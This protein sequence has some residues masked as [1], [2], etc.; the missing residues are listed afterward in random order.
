MI[1]INKENREFHLQGPNT[2][3]IFNVM[4]NEQLGHLYFGKKIRHRESFKHFFYQPE[5]GIG[6]IAH[7]EDDP[8]FSLEYYKQEYPSYGTTDFRKPAFELES[9]DGSRVSDFVYKGY[10][11]YKGKERLDGLPSTYVE[12]EDEAN[13]LEIELKDEVL[14]CKLFLTYTVYKN[15]DVITRNA[16]FVNHGTEKIDINR[17][18]SFALDLPDY[19]YEI[20]HLS[21]AWARERFIKT[22]KLEVGSQ[23]I[24]STRGASSAHQNP[25]IILKRPNTTEDSGESIGFAL[26]YSG[27][28]LAH[29][30]VD[31]FDATRVTMGI[32]PFDFKWNL[33]PGESFTTPE[34]IIVYS[35]NGMNE[36]SKTFHKLFRERVARGEW[37]DKE[38]PILV[39]NWE[40][41]YFDFNED[42]IVAMASKAKK[43]GF[44]LF[45]LD[46]GWFGKR[47]DDKTS[48][49]DWFPNL[50]KLPNGVKGLGERVVNEDI[51]FGLWFEP[52]MISKNSKLYEEH[53]DWILGVKNRRLSMG[54]NQ[55]ILDLSKPEV[56]KYIVD[57]LSERFSEAPISYVKWDMNR[58]MTEIT[59]RDLPHKY[60]L[61]LYE[62]LEELTT[63]FPH[64]L[65]ESCAS[66]GGRFDAGMLH[67]MPQV[68][69]SDDTDAIV[70]LNIQH[71]TSLA[72]PLISMGAH[73]SDIPNHQTARKTSLECRNHVAAF[74]NFGYELDLLKFDESTEE[75]VKKHLEFYKENRRLI[76]FGDFYRLESPF[77]GNSAAWMVVD[78]ERE[79]ALVGHFTIL[80]SPNPGYN[81]KVILKGLNPDKKYSVNGEFEAY[82]DELMNVGIVFPQPDR[83][84]SKD[85]ETQ[86][87]K[88][89]VFKLKEVK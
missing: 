40:A 81:A 87:F 53:P 49:G 89:K 62:I 67:Y 54:R 69:T 20:I 44:E 39:N 38:R 84:F 33:N 3:Y 88:S 37:R 74:G 5:V 8:G 82:G 76:Q 13:T 77:E 59:Y 73:V 19:N 17:A 7:H 35:E 30:E 10:R 68:W 12:S 85:S 55:Y 45:V 4:K 2:S 75:S 11:V 21:G 57:I 65:F 58:N 47:D 43:L 9:E 48:L 16:R 18:M 28:F 80:A 1:Y 34:A 23:Y 36:M 79:E 32:N 15:R 60:I 71:G 50:D 46:D 24:D 22:R 70:R 26:V 29:V 52:E 86:D 42:K 6:I 31:H 25:F 56:R 83:Y 72:Y 41:T 61:G 27:N 51:R 14:N 66:G 64:I 63:K 78:K